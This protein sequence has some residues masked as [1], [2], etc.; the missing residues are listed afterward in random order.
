MYFLKH[1]LL[2]V[3]SI[4]LLTISS[5]DDHGAAAAADFEYLNDTLTNLAFGSCH[6]A[7]KIKPNDP[8]IWKQIRENEQPQAFVWAGDAVYPPQRR[9]ASPEQLRELYE[10]MNSNETIGYAGWKPPLGIFGTWDDH[11]YGGNDMGREMPNKNERAQAFYEFLQ[12]PALTDDRDGLYYSVTFGEPPQQTKLILLD[13]RW[14]RGRHCLPSLATNIPL[15]AGIS[16]AIRWALAGFNVNAWWP[17]WDCWSTSVL[18]KDQWTWL[19]QELMESKAQ[20]NVVVSSIQVLTTNPTVES[21]GHFP[22]ERQHLLKLLGRGISGLVV[23]SGDVHHAE[24]LDPL[25]A[26]LMKERRSFLEVTSSGMTHDC[27]QPVYGAMCKPILDHYNQHRFET[28][29]NIY[30]GKNYGSIL[31]NWEEQ[32]MQVLIKN[33][34]GAVALDT[35]IRSFHQEALTQDEIDGIVPCVDGHMIQPFL[36]IFM[37]VIGIVL[38]GATGLFFSR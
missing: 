33:E 10:D 19:E 16:A 23:L 26:L 5:H 2:L 29:N 8:N 4:A 22:Y 36:K 27:S 6:N 25:A 7:F 32:S 35:G 11:D 12:I 1:S 34:V 38:I 14:H 30:I 28:T 13:T 24:I 15:G 20:V 37:T 18:G 31:I 3:L 17:F 21:W 9:V